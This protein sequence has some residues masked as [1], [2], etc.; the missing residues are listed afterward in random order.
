MNQSKIEWLKAEDGSPGS[1]WNPLRAEHGRWYC[2]KTSP[3]CANCY[4]E[5][6]NLRFGGQPYHEGADSLLPVAGTDLDTPFRWHKPR[7]VF[8]CSMTD[9]FLAAFDDIDKIFAA[10]VL[11]WRHTY[12]V[13][14]KRAA[15]MQEYITTHD[16]IGQIIAAADRTFAGDAGKKTFDLL[17]GSGSPDVG[18]PPRNV[19]LGV[20][21]E[22][23][24]RAEA[25]I[26]LLKDT[27]AAVRF[28]SFEP[29][30]SSIRVGDLFA[31]PNPI[32]WAI[33]GGESGPASRP[34]EPQWVSCL[35]TNVGKA[36][37]LGFFK[38]WGE[39]APSYAH[40]YNPGV[41]I[42]ASVRYTTEYSEILYRFGRS[43]IRPILSGGR[44]WSQ[45]PEEAP[46]WAA[47]KAD[48]EAMN[49][50][51]RKPDTL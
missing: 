42:P 25:R 49:A 43:R 46:A 3:G 15:R 47:A 4:A 1:S 13:L 2:I 9:L 10:M 34:M 19:W 38:Q 22:D 8:V 7:R 35:L 48:A 24:D 16:R 27:P 23:Q 30:L 17:D 5:R 18:W 41:S 29:L 45:V 14:T 21:A 32:H 51:R 36:G 37:V 28:V 20:T 39:W 31:P 12:L 50:P 40:Y 6:I 26:P 33:I 44:E 11:C